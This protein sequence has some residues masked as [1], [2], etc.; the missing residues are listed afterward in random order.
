MCLS[1]Q[2]LGRAA[3]R[4]EPPSRSGLIRRLGCGHE[5]RSKSLILEHQAYMEPKMRDEIDA[6]VVIAL[7]SCAHVVMLCA[8]SGAHTA[9]GRFEGCSVLHATEVAVAVTA[10]AEAEANARREA[11][12]AGRT[13]QGASKGSRD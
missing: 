3:P 12:A 7:G 2:A 4:H 9:G 1:H 6:Y 10:D 8:A 11:A 5:A 13:Q